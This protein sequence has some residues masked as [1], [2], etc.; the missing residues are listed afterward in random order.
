[1]AWMK[2]GKNAAKPIKKCKKKRNQTGN[3]RFSGRLCARRRQLRV[4]AAN[5]SALLLNALRQLP[6]HPIG[7][8][9]NDSGVL[10]LRLFAVRLMN[11]AAHNQNGLLL[12]DCFANSN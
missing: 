10:D 12:Q 1:M 11:M 9:I 6:F 7:A 3:N 8:S 4:R 2:A 5:G